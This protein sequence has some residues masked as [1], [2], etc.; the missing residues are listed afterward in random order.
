M[1]LSTCTV[2]CTNCLWSIISTLAELVISYLNSVYVLH[3]LFALRPY[4]F[5]RTTSVLCRHIE[6]NF[7]QIP[8]STQTANTY[9]DTPILSASV[10]LWDTSFDR[11]IILD[12]II[13]EASMFPGSPVAWF[14]GSWLSCSLV[15]WNLGSLAPWFPG[16]LVHWFPSSLV[17]WFP[18]ALRCGT[19]M[20]DLLGLA[21]AFV[22][23]L[24][25]VLVYFLVLAMVRAPPR[26]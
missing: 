19:I 4:Y 8:D 9:G 11:D 17:P 26:C 2:V 24:A 23:T 10:A 14:L 15:P 25:F 22:L 18:G 3:E 1:Y 13:E 16:S 5:G 12:E 21:S 20:S 6:A 7:R